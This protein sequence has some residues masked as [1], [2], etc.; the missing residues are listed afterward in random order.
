MSALEY[1]L[2]ELEIARKSDDPRHIMPTM[3]ERFESIL[4]LGCG[5][6]QTLIGN[7]LKPGVFACGV[8]IDEEALTLGRKL[9]EEIVFVRARGE[10]LPFRNNAFDVVISRVALPYTA[11]P[12]TL[13]EIARVLKPGGHVWLTLHPFSM[14]SAQMLTSVKAGNLKSIIYQLYVL[15]NSLLFHLAGRQISFPFN[16]ERC[17]S[18]QTVG[19]IT[20]AMERVGFEGV[21]ADRGHF[22]IV[23]ANKRRGKY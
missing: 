23:T 5:A 11:I 6:G 2:A 14:L 7:G 13:Q 20:R 15:A 16:R 4:D 22:F 3:P 18:V 12:A 21:R 10:K 19:A 1:H 8:D 9:S 17:E